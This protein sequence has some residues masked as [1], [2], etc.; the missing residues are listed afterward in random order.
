MLSNPDFSLSLS[1]PSSPSF[2]FSLKSL[3]FVYNNFYIKYY[4]Y[5]I[6]ILYTFMKYYLSHK[7]VLTFF[8]DTRSITFIY[9]YSSLFIN[10]SVSSII[11]TDPRRMP[12][13]DNDLS[14]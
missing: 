6:K 9:K 5:K 14:I 8:V 7:F 1:L 11:C 3:K 2:S 12:Y 10:R 13:N 4:K